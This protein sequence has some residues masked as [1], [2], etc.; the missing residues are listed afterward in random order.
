M[1]KWHQTLLL[2]LLVI[3]LTACSATEMTQGIQVADTTQSITATPEPTPTLTASPTP[4]PTLSPQELVDEGE[5]ALYIGDYDRAYQIFSNAFAQSEDET[6]KTASQL[7]MGQSFYIQ[8][9]Y[10][11]ALNELR[12]AANAD[13]PIIAARANYILGQCYT[14][15]DR[16]EEALQA[17]NNYLDLR[18]GLIDFNVYEMQGDKA[19]VIAGD[20]GEDQASAAKDGADQCPV[21]AIEV[22]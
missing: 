8:G 22:S 2:G 1:I 12:E 14:Q 18:P 6:T 9:I 20:I 17:Y 10:D 13:D 7:G 16:Y 11:Q 4:T 21:N 15:L 19:V 5:M 3:S